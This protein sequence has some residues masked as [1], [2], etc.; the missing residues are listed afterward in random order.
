MST[1]NYNISFWYNIILMIFYILR[2]IKLRLLLVTLMLLVTS[3][4]PPSST[5]ASASPK[6]SST[7][8]TVNTNTTPQVNPQPAPVTSQ[9]P[10]ITISG[11][12]KGDQYNVDGPLWY[13]GTAKIEEFNNNEMKININMS[14]PAVGLQFQLKDGKLNIS[15]RLFRDSKLNCYLYDLNSG[16]TYMLPNPKLE[17]G[18][19]EAGWFS[20]S[21][22]FA[23][24]ISGSQFYNFTMESQ[25]VISISSSIMPGGLTLTKK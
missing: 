24:I 5:K 8:T 9:P 1:M 13:D 20:T 4:S 18:K 3:C 16:K 11:F 10:L 6:P 7:P 17:M 12:K 21:K 19:T 14:A 23:K 15:I 2:I 22:E 25:T